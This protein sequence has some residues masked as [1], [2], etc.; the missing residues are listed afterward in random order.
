MPSRGIWTRITLFAATI[1]AALSFAVSTTGTAHADTFDDVTPP[2]VTELE[3]NVTNYN[4]PLPLKTITAY[5]Q[6]G[7]TPHD[8]AEDWIPA[9]RWRDAASLQRACGNA[10]FNPTAGLA[11]SIT[12]GMA[13]MLFGLAGFIWWLTLSFVRIATAFSPEALPDLLGGQINGI[14]L[15]LT[16]S[17]IASGLFAIALGVAALQVYRSMSR[18]RRNKAW[19]R[20]A[21]IILPLVSL[22]VMAGAASQ[23]TS[24]DATAAGQPT[25]NPGAATGSPLWISGMGLSAVQHLTGGLGEALTRPNYED[26]GPDG[27]S[28]AAYL[29]AMDQVRERISDSDEQARLGNVTTLGR[30]WEQGFLAHWSAAQYKT[31]DLDRN[32]MWCHQLEAANRTPRHEQVLIGDLAG[33]PSVDLPAG[34]ASGSGRTLAEIIDASDLSDDTCADAPMYQPGTMTTGIDLSSGSCGDWGADGTTGAITD[35]LNSVLG[36]VTGGLAGDGNTLSNGWDSLNWAMDQASESTAELCAGL[37]DSDRATMDVCVDAVN[38]T[39]VDGWQVTAS[40]R[41]DP[42][43]AGVYEHDALSYFASLYPWQACVYENGQWKVQAGWHQVSRAAKEANGGSTLEAR[44]CE[45][46]W[47]LGV[48]PGRGAGGDDD[49]FE[50][51]KVPPGNMSNFASG[52]GIADYNPQRGDDTA[53]EARDMVGAT[54]GSPL[55][56]GDGHLLWAFLALATAVVMA[57]SLGA[58]AGGAIVANIAFAALLAMLPVTLVL[59]VIGGGSENSHGRRLLRMTIAYA[60]TAILMNLGI[61]FVIFITHLVNQFAANLAGGF[62]TIFVLISPIVAVI[63]LKRIVERAGF[64]DITSLRGAAAAVVAAGAVASHSGTMTVTDP[65]TGKQTK[66]SA[67]KHALNRYMNQGFGKRGLLSPVDASGNRRSGLVARMEKRMEQAGHA[68]ADRFH[69]IKER[70]VGEGTALHRLRHHRLSDGEY[71]NAEYRRL[72]A[73]NDGMSAAGQIADRF[74]EKHGKESKFGAMAATAGAFISKLDD[75]LSVDD[76]EKARRANARATKAYYDEAVDGGATPE[77]AAA[78]AVSRMQDGLLSNLLVERDGRGKPRTTPSGHAIYGFAAIGDGEPVRVTAEEAGYDPHTGSTLRGFEVITDFSQLPAFSSDVVEAQRREYATQ[79]GVDPKQV[80]V[81]AFGAPP[82][83]LPPTG[84]SGHLKIRPEDVSFDALHEMGRQGSLFFGDDVR[85]QIDALE[86]D[87]AKVTA[88]GH[89]RMTSGLVDIDGHE[90]SAYRKLGISE[91]Q[92]ERGLEEMLQGKT[93]HA[94]SGFKIDVSGGDL[95]HALS[96][97]RN[98]D[99]QQRALSHRHEITV[100]LDGALREVGDAIRGME[101]GTAR[102]KAQYLTRMQ[103]D[104]NAGDLSEAMQ[105]EMAKMQETLSKFVEG[106]HELTVRGQTIS[107]IREQNH[108]DTNSAEAGPEMMKIVEQ[109]RRFGA[110]VDNLALDLDDARALVANLNAAPEPGMPPNLDRVME[111]LAR[112]EEEQERLRRTLAD[113]GESSGRKAPHARSF[114]TV[115]RDIDGSRKRK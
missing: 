103:A 84:K 74:A 19:Q 22:T 58:L 26:R 57:F 109:L 78:T 93:S 73:G 110:T 114:F 9:L 100:E 99:R 18:G 54:F 8:E 80:I 20:I 68:T 70:T 10:L 35:Y 79:F 33:Y 55:I 75:T 111:I 107:N 36:T 112:G 29:D 7:L 105:A 24:D 44:H 63:I 115:L 34:A 49:V 86:T 43:N 47:Y 40:G 101:V 77:E 30:L 61:T 76:A 13:S 12:N 45:E 65:D 15:R 59:L 1:I 83:L 28:C 81:D 60:G 5:A 31:A 69:G 71:S 72:V 16:S 66:V 108:F 52:P 2:Q 25:M 89:I 48:A 94:L 106:L 14:F 38:D 102:E 41:R 4:D 39:E 53:Q 6:N 56:V 46:W 87:E 37:D 42:Y 98:V 17:I 62:S 82:M 32:Q 90:I 67:R 92:V 64:G 95:A 51:A 97:G 91:A 27:V 96:A 21:V 104:N 88:I 85:R 23:E 3:S 50:K 113:L 11:C